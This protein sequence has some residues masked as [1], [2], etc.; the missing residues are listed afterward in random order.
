MTRPRHA[1][2]SAAVVLVLLATGCA[3]R[4]SVTQ[5]AAPPPTGAPVAVAPA[6][7]PIPVPEPPRAEPPAP[8][9]AE[10]APAPVVTARPVPQGRPERPV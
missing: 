6:P 1:L 4:P 2:V 9:P 8:A 7:A 10:P 5:A 3:R